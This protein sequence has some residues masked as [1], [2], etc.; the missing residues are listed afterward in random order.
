LE[1]T[2][3]A[4]CWPAAASRVIVAGWPTKTRT[5]PAPR[6]AA[7]TTGTLAAPTVATVCTGSAKVAYAEDECCATFCGT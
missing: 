1:V 4:V 6:L 5:W 3:S 2:A 7:A